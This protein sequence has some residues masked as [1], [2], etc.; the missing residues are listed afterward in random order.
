VITSGP[1]HDSIAF[2]RVLGGIRI[3]RRGRGRP[4]TR[5]A[6]LLGDKAFS[7]ASIRN[8]L[9]RRGIRAT[10]PQPTDQIRHRHARGRRG[11]RPRAFDRDRY[12]QRNI[13]ERCLSRLKQ[14]RAVATRYD[15]RD[16]M[17]RATVDVAAIRIW[18]TDPVP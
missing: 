15:K 2:T 7:N 14:C 3:R 10:I 8:H 12:K 13:V 4:R 17:Y 5:P 11:G 16:Y 6:H 18:L 1:R 9:R